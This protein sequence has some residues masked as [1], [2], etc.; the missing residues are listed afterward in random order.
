MFNEI[1]KTKYM[2]DYKFLIISNVNRLSPYF[3]FDSR[4]KYSEDIS[5][6]IS[7]MPIILVPSLFVDKVSKQIYFYNRGVVFLFY[8]SAM[9]KSH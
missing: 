8:R 3:K 2:Y 7:H 5:I 6:V 1:F 9:F 4:K